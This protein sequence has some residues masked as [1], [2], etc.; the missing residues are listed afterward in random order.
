MQPAAST[1]DANLQ[2]LTPIGAG[3]EHPASQGSKAKAL[4][5]RGEVLITDNWRELRALE[6]TDKEHSD[7]QA[8]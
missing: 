4:A 1:E 5:L 8:D 7:C 3:F 2:K 6:L